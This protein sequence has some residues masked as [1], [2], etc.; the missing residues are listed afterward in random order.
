VKTTLPFELRPKHRPEDEADI[1]RWLKE[2]K[3]S[4]CPTVAVEPTV[5]AVLNPESTREVIAVH[6]TQVRRRGQAGLE[7]AYQRGKKSSGKTQNTKFD[8]FRERMKPVFAALIGEGNL[9]DRELA[10]KLNAAGYMNTQGRPWV[11]GSVGPMRR[12]MCL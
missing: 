4:K 3:P 1:N 8:E 2:N 7:A 5:S 9:S 11:T 6:A 12:K 10:E